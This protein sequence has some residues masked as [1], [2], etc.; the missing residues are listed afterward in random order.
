M[1]AV[2]CS[3][4]LHGCVARARAEDARYELALRR[5]WREKFERQR[6]RPEQ[7]PSSFELQRD[8]CGVDALRALSESQK[9]DETVFIVTSP[10]AAG[11]LRN[12]SARA[13]SVTAYAVGNSTAK[14]PK[15]RVLGTECGNA[16]S[17][18]TTLTTDARTARGMY[19]F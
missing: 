6:R 4:R 5:A 17:S 19:L 7:V 3:R 9:L 10:R 12:A 11:F 15:P 13:E 18:P 1:R 2:G 16:A 14:R 8:R